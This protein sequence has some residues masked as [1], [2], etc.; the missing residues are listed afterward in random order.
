M[1]SGNVEKK[2][3][4]ALSELYEALRKRHSR[5]ITMYGNLIL[6]TTKYGE[7]KIYQDYTMFPGNDHT[8][9]RNGKNVEEYCSFILSNLN[10]LSMPLWKVEKTFYEVAPGKWEILH[11]ASK[12]HGFLALSTPP[13]GITYFNGNQCYF[14]NYHK[15]LRRGNRTLENFCKYISDNVEV[16][17]KNNIRDILLE[18]HYKIKTVKITTREG[19]GNPF[20]NGQRT[21]WHITTQYGNVVADEDSVRFPG[22]SYVYYRRGKS[23]EDFASFIMEGIEKYSNLSRNTITDISDDDLI[24]KELENIHADWCDLLDSFVSWRKKREAPDDITKAAAIFHEQNNSKIQSLYE[25]FANAVYMQ[26]SKYANAFNVTIKELC[27]RRATTFLGQCY[28]NENR[29]EISTSCIALPVSWI[30]EVILHE[31]CHLFIHGH[32]LNFYRKLEEMCHAAGLI[33]K[34]GYIIPELCRGR[35]NT[36]SASEHYITQ[37]E[38]EYVYKYRL[39]NDL[40]DSREK[41]NRFVF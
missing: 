22:N 32:S 37:P 25:S 7:V 9:R 27:L 13:F 34:C 38:E 4:I 41:V 15:I 11:G 17:F 18:H 1:A 31:I 26:T 24:G 2:C 40:V 36:L 10:R 6:M 35:G 3:D 33:K 21:E 29:I 23:M 19:G 39:T 20:Q 5:K 8:Y 16:Y 14:P 28:W 30:R 12:R